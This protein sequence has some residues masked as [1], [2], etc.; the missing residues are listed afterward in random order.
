SEMV[1]VKSNVYQSNF[2]S[3]N[4]TPTDLIRTTY[5][6]PSLT[7]DTDLPPQIDRKQPRLVRIPNG[8]RPVDRLI[9]RRTPRNFVGSYGAPFRQL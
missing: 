6:A 8:L 9:L 7:L 3:D 2:S 5:L 4:H 1:T